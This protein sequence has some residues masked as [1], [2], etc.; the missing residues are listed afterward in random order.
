MFGNNSTL[1]YPLIPK[2]VLDSSG[3][4]HVSPSGV[5]EGWVIEIMCPG[6]DNFSGLD[7]NYSDI[8]QR[9]PGKLLIKLHPPSDSITGVIQLNLDLHSTS[10][11]I[12]LHHQTSVNVLGSVR[13][14]GEGWFSNEENHCVEMVVG[15]ESLPA[16]ITMDNPMWAIVGGETHVVDD[17]MTVSYT[18]L[19]LPTKA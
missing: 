13:I 2:G 14:L 19:T 1:E 17:P 4:I 10:S 3:S 12:T 8:S 11:G 9:S 16:N 18:H 15:L 6:E 5:I 7:C